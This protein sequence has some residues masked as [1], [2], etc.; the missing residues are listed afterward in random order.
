MDQVTTF[1]FAGWVAILGGI[2]FLFDKSESVASRDTKRTISRWLKNL[3]SQEIA[4]RWPQHFVDMFDSVFGHRHLTLKCFFRSSIASIVSVVIIGL[5]W[6]GLY[7]LEFKHVVTNSRAPWVSLVYIVALILLVNVLPD[8]LSLL[9]TRL[10]LALIANR[11]S[12]IAVW[13]GLLV[14]VIATGALAIGSVYFANI[15]LGPLVLTIFFWTTSVDPLLML[16][17]AYSQLW[18][19]LVRGYRPPLPGIFA[20]FSLSI[21]SKPCVVCVPWGVWAF[22]SFFT[23]AWLWTYALAG[24]LVKRLYWV[25]VAINALDIHEKPI[26]SLGWVAMVLVTI[27]YWIIAIIR[28]LEAVP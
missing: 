14:D 3:D 21:G 20:I 28:V 12:R 16:Q 2:W 6:A 27:A 15:L 1:T 10:V 26:T 18:Q 5:L 7:P 4:S 13:V 23:S 24:A 9:E 22:A 19:S 11:G 25:G 8:Y 17:N